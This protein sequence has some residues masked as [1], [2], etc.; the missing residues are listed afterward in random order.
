MKRTQIRVGHQ[1]SD[2]ALLLKD[3][4]SIDSADLRPGHTVVGGLDAS[5]NPTIQPFISGANFEVSLEFI[6]QEGLTIDQ[7]FMLDVFF[8]SQDL[9][10]RDRVTATEILARDRERVRIMTPLS[11]RDETESLGPMI[12]RELD[13]LTDFGLLPPMPEELI[14][15]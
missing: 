10:G 6:E 8:M 4:S 13:I 7:A 9:E 5:G 11:G 14:E 1:A 15:A 3:D 12:E 2:P